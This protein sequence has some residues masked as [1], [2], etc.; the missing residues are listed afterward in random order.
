MNSTYKKSGG[1][2]IRRSCVYFKNGN[3]LSCFSN[4]DP[5]AL[6]TQNFFCFARFILKLH[7][8]CT[9]MKTEYNMTGQLFFCQ[10]FQKGFI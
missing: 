10:F 1:N 8:Y 7:Y 3:W 9:I 2:F 6:R 4:E 5:I